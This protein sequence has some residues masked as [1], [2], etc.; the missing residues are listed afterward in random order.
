MGADFE[1]ATEIRKV[2]INFI[3]AADFVSREDE[4]QLAEQFFI[5]HNHTQKK[6]VYNYLTEA[7]LGA[8]HSIIAEVPSAQRIEV[9]VLTSSRIDI[10]ETTTKYLILAK[11]TVLDKTGKM[12]ILPTT[13]HF[14]E[15]LSATTEI[16]MEWFAHP[17]G[18]NWPNGGKMKDMH[19][20]KGVVAML[21]EGIRFGFHSS[22]RHNGF[23][24]TAMGE[25]AVF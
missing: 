19:C 25:T 22:G 7:S 23:I 6:P 5:P 17:N 1:T 10:N 4:N 15:P 9:C 20:W 3:S 14:G 18:E 13:Y 16:R 8:N 2:L 24:S 12:I 11:I 21:R